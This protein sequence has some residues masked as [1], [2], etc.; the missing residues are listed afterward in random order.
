[1][2]EE[3]RVGVLGEGRCG[4][5]ADRGSCGGEFVRWRHAVDTSGWPPASGCTRFLWG[6]CGGNANNF[7]TEEECREACPG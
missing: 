1:M 2:G 3:R 4:L 7:L 6:G 5:P